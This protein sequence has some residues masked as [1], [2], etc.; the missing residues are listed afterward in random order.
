[1]CGPKGG[2]P[3]LGPE[4]GLMMGTGVFDRLMGSL[5]CSLLGQLNVWVGSSY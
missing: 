3:G 1:M 4:G 2:P 5:S